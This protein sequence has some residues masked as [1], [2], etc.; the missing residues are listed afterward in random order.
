[1][2]QWVLYVSGDSLSAPPIEEEIR[3]AGFSPR[4]AP[5]RARSASLLAH[6]EPPVA[7]VVDF[8]T[9]RESDLAAIREAAPEGPLIA[10]NAPDGIAVATASVPP[11][12]KGVLAAALERLTR[13]DQEPDDG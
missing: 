9:V 4:R 2:P 12:M 10:V 5:D 8:S 11:R 6:G 7:V 1:M 3:M 13:S